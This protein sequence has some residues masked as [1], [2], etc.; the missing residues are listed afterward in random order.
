MT[1]FIVA[2]RSR[3]D[4][5]LPNIFGNH[6]FSVVPRSMFSADGCLLLGSDKSTVLHQIEELVPKTDEPLV[7]DANNKVLIIDGMVLVNQMIKTKDIKTCQDFANKFIR[8]VEIASGDYGEVRISLKNL[9]SE[10]KVK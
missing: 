2:S 5:D 1:R 6:E 10:L 7:S 8:N 3:D 4:I 9:I